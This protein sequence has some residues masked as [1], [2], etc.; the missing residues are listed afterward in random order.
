MNQTLMDHA[1]SIRLSDD[2]LE[3]F[4]AEAFNTACYL[5][6]R[7]PSVA[8]VCKIPQEVWSR[9]PFENSGLW[10]LDALLTLV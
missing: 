2:L 8:T 10:I 7:S 9:K 1:Q 5:E 6:N 4:W 3:K